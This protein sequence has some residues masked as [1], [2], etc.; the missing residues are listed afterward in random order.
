M[1]TWHNPLNVSYS[2]MNVLRAIY[3]IN[4]EHRADR[5]VA[6]QKQLSRI[7]WHADFFS[8]I[9]PE[10][11]TNFPSIGA[12]GCFLSHVAVLKKAQNRGVQQLVIL[13][14][15]VN[16]AP[17]FSERWNFSMSALEN[18]EWSIFYPGHLLND[19][20]AGL[21]RI[22][23]SVGV[24]CTHFM[25]INGHAISTL[26]RGLETILSR[27][28]GHP[29]G[30]PMHVDGAYST[31]RLQDHSLTTYVYF[32]ALGYQRPSRTDVANLKWF[33]RIGMLAPI[34]SIARRL[35]AFSKPSYKQ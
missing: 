7:G 14:D 8:A 1:A 16:F 24:R 6:I 4:L 9:R 29:L 30:G 15:D 23:P 5:R 21:Q 11:A 28:A 33:D 13:E 26:I 35:K 31:I 27:P 19:L 34:I 2:T 32:P 18:K 10:S 3:V 12:R 20:P 25:V 17:S 22:S